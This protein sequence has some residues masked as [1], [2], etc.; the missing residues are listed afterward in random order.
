MTAALP[1]LRAIKDAEELDRPPAAARPRT[2]ASRRLEARFAGRKGDGRW[3]QIPPSCRSTTATQVDFTGGRLGL[4]GNPH[5]EA[6]DWTIEEGDMIVLGLRWPRV[7]TVTA[8][9]RHA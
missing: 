4:N 1:M 5:H 2:N 8:L 7:R 9:T 6:G 3:R